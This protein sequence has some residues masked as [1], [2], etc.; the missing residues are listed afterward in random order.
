MTRKIRTMMRAVASEPIGVLEYR[1]NTDGPKWE[2]VTVTIN[3]PPISHM[4]LSADGDTIV[5][6]VHTTSADSVEA[7]RVSADPLVEQQVDRL[8]FLHG[9]NI[10]DLVFTS[11]SVMPPPHVNSDGTVTYQTIALG[12][13]AMITDSA[14]GGP[15]SLGPGSREQL[16][17]SLEEA[18]LSGEAYFRR[19]RKALATDESVGKFM[20]LYQIIE[21]LHGMPPRTQQDIDSAIQ[22]LQPG[23]EVKPSPHRP[24]VNETVYTRLRN[25]TGHSRQGASFEVTRAEIKQHLNGLTEL[26]KK[27]ISEQS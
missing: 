17:D 10:A 14:T 3:Q 6:L 18:G 20:A 13:R 1:A 12:A 7:A 19:F 8:A 24:T 21:T 27:A 4:E 15:M 2:T 11:G 9:C 25:E 23:V 16:R 22:R 5:F 26:V